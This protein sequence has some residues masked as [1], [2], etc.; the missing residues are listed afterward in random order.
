MFLIASTSRPIAS[1]TAWRAGRHAQ[2]KIRRLPPITISVRSDAIRP[3]TAPNPTLQAEIWN[4]QGQSVGR[5][6]YAIS[7]L[8][9]KV[10]VYELKIKR[11]HRRR[12][13]GT[14]FLAYLANTN[15]LS[16]TP[17]HETHEET[18]FWNAA[19]RLRA[20]GVTVTRDLRVGEMDAEAQRWQHLQ[21]AS[22]LPK[23][24]SVDEV[25]H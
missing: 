2:R 22:E 7:P 12:G 11:V 13:Y 16:I 18:A 14:A 9:D 25:L 21:P 1:L 24:V 23:Y 17:I 4:E 6:R 10:Y 20:A 5:A 8:N 15:A 19:R 3:W